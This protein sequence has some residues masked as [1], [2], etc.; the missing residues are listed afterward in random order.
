VLA[1]KSIGF[2]ICEQSAEVECLTEKPQCRR[3]QHVFRNRSGGEVG[4]GGGP[5][6][7][8]S[9]TATGE[10]EENWGSWDSLGEQVRVV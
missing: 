8:A 4:R 2:P 6:L 3:D 5:A 1:M 9:S 7:S 10:R